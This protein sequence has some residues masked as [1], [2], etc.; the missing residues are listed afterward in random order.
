MHVADFPACDLVIAGSGFFGATIAERAARELGLRVLVLDRRDHIGGNAWSHIDP[1]TG[2]EVHTYGSHLFHTSNQQVWDYVN[3]FSRFSS[4]RHRV[5]VRHNNR[6]FT[7]PMNLGT[8]S[9]LFGRFLSPSDAKALIAAE[10]AAAGIDKPANFEEK[11]ISLAGRTMYDAFIKGYT[12]KQWQTDPR[13]L[14]AEIISRL[15][16]RLTFDVYYFN[17]TYEGLPLDGYAAI[18]QRMLTHENIHIAT[19]VD[20][21]DVRARLPAVPVIYTGPVDR[22]F[23]Y[24]AGT[25]GWRTIDFESEV[26]PT[27]DFQGASVV[28][29]PDMDV[30]FTRIHEF[31]H[32]HPERT[33]QTE[34][35]IIF[36]EFSRF[37]GRADEPYYPINATADKVGYD[38]Y[39]AMADA[40]PGVIFGGRLGTYRYLDMHQAIGAAMKVFENQVAPHV[41][42]G[43]ALKD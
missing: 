31:R 30:P 40:E 2:I 15:P 38:A 37:A 9:S 43:K 11:A 33:Y 39:R 7:M 32:L 25:L 1:A 16:M 28:N 5:I 42:A 13:E 41:V 29:Y 20:Y 21:F 26:T 12:A 36:R 6:F 24:R 23:G 14:P 35:S 10:V 22:Y 3:R 27:G 4:Y 19:G 18:F 8:L 17:D 34:K